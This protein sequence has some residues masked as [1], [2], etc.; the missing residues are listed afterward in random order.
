[1]VRDYRA[2]A[3][4]IGYVLGIVCRSTSRIIGNCSLHIRI[5][6]NKEAELGYTFKREEW[7]NGYATE[8]AAAM[9]EFGFQE[10]G[11]HRRFAS[12]SPAD[13]ASQRVLEKLGMTREGLLRKNVLQQTSGG[14]P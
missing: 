5:A 7:G 4:R 2:D 14:I 13:S 6:K 12:T 1:M 11:L 3:P 8:S 9:I 10:P